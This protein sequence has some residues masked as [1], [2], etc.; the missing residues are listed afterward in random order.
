MEGGTQEF[1]KASQFVVTR[2]PL[3]VAT[4]CIVMQRAAVANGCEDAGKQ[5]LG[6]QLV[7]AGRFGR[8]QKFIHG[9]QGVAISNLA[10]PTNH[11]HALGFRPLGPY[12]VP[13]ADSAMSTSTAPDDGLFLLIGPIPNAM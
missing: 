12:L 6:A 4:E 5:A 7:V 3:S 13:V 2:W 11:L 9:V 10:A 8:L 1:R